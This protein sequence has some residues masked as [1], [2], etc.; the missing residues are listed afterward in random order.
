MRKT[1]LS[2]VIL[3]SIIVVSLVGCR[4]NV[5]TGEFDSSE[6][7]YEEN[8]SSEDY[9]NNETEDELKEYYD[10]SIM[11]EN[12]VANFDM[13]VEGFVEAYNASLTSEAD[14]IANNLSSPR[15]TTGGIGVQQISIKQY[16]VSNAATKVHTFVHTNESEKI[17]EL[18]VGIEKQFGRA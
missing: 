7:A 14:Y 2:S 12:D 4:G 18:V 17:V 16:D 10:T 1:I 8:S 6:S 3:L 11:F 15:Y 9:A 5:S 13:G